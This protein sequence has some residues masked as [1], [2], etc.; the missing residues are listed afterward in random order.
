MSV[1]HVRVKRRNSACASAG[2]SDPPLKAVDPIDEKRLK[3]LVTLGADDAD[4]SAMFD[5][6]IASLYRRFGKEL[7]RWRAE[8]RAQIG[9]MIWEVAKGGNATILAWLGKVELRW[10]DEGKS[11][12]GGTAPRKKPKP[13]NFE[14]FST[15]FH[16]LFGPPP[17]S[18][19]DSKS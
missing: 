11:N 4:L 8:R 18:P 2:D 14:A 19:D 10:I 1:Q 17:E 5:V 15:E 6:S 12:V 13:F 3:A 7:R 16:R 9:Q